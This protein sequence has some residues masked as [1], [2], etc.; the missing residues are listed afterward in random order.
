MALNADRVHAAVPG[1]IE[2]ADGLRSQANA[3][4]PCGDDIG[5]NVEM[6]EVPHRVVVDQADTRVYR[7]MV[8]DR[9]SVKE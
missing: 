3:A 4:E 1:G 9:R 2:D 5:F 7:Q 6:V 8:A